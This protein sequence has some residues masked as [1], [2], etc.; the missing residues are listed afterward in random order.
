MNM[1]KNKTIQRILAMALSVVLVLTTTPVTALTAYAQGG[2]AC[3]HTHD[4]ACGY[5]EGADC[6]LG[7]GEDWDEEFEIA[8]AAEATPTHVC[9]EDCDEYYIHTEHDSGCGYIAAAPCKHEHDEDCGGLPKMPEKPG[10]TVESATNTDFVTVLGFSTPAVTATVPLGTSYGDLPL[11]ETVSATVEDEPDPADVPVEW[12]DD[13]SYDGD[14]TGD[15]GFTGDLDAGYILA[16]G[17]NPP[18]FT[19][20][21]ADTAVLR[22]ITAF[23]E[24]PEDI[25]FQ[26]GYAPKLPDTVEGTV[27]VETA[28]IP[29]TWQSEEYDSLGVAGGLAVF[30]AKPAEGYITADGVNPPTI[31]FMRESMLRMGGAGTSGSPLQIVSAAQLAE[32]AA[33]V[34]ASKLEQTVFGVNTGTVYLELMNDI[35]LS[36]YGTGTGWMPIGNLNNRFQGQFNGGGKTVSGLYINSTSSRIG[37]FGHVAEGAVVQNL[38]VVNVNVKGS[39]DV[40]G[41]AGQVNGTVKN[42]YAT[43]SV[44]GTN[45]VGGVA[46]LVNGGTVQ[47]CYATAD[48]SGTN[49][50]GGVAGRISSGS[51]VENCYATADVSGTNHVGGVVGSVAGGTV[52]SCAALNPSVSGTSNVGRVIGGSAGTNNYAYSGMDCTGSDGTSKTAAQI[53]AAG[54][55]ET[56]FNNDSA[57]TYATG[58]LPGFG[59]AVPMPA[60]LLTGTANPFDGGTGASDN[61][62]QISTAEQLA[63]L[64][65]KVNAGDTDYNA[66]YYKLTADIDLSAYS[67]G[68][69]W[70]PIGI[71]STNPFK[72]QFDGGEHTVSG[73]FIN[74][75]ILD[76]IGLFGVVESGATVQN[77]GVVNAEIKGD[78][79]VGGVAGRVSGTV[80]NCY[81]TGSVSGTNSVGGVVGEISGGTVQNCYATGSVNGTRYVGG[82]AG[83]VTGTSATVQNCYA[84]G[85]V[86]GTRYVGGVAGE[87]DGGTVKNCVALNSSVS[88]TIDV[89]RVVGYE[90]GTN[91][92]TNNYAYDYM[93]CNAIGDNTV[94]GTGTIATD[95]AATDFWTYTSNWDGPVWDE[96]VW[97]IAAIKLPGL[98]GK[99]VTM[100][101]HLLGSNAHPF[102]GGDGAELTPYEISTA[103]QLAW[104]AERVN[105][106]SNAYA[107]ADVYYK[108]T[109]DIDL[110][111]YGASFNSGK[112]WIPIGYDINKPFQGKFDGNGKTVSGLYINDSTRYSTGLF[113]HVASGAAVQNLG[114][115]NVDV[116]GYN[117]VGGV[118]GEVYGTVENC[119]ATGSVSGTGTSQY[120]GGV[121]GQILNGTVQN[122]YATGSVTGNLCVGGVAGCVESGTMQNCYATGSVIG[123]NYVGGVA[124]YVNG[125]TVQNCAALNPSVSGSSN[126]GRVIGYNTGGTVAKNYAY[127]GMSC[128]SKGTNCDDGAAMTASDAHNAAFWTTTTGN[129]SGWDNST[130]WTIVDD[131]LPV[132]T[133][134]NGQDGGSGMYLTTKTIENATISGSFT[135]TGSA[136]WPTVTLGGVALTEGTD[137]TASVTGGTSDGTNVGT[138][139]VTITGKGNYT[140]TTTG[141]YTITKATPAALTLPTATTITYGAALSTSD[142]NGGSATGTWEWTVPATIPTVVNSGYEVTFTPADT[143]NYDWTGVSGWDSATSTIRRTVI[144]TVNKAVP[145]A[146]T[147]PTAAT[148]TYGAALSTSALNGGTGAGTFAWTNGTTIPTVTNSGYEVTFTPTDTSNYDWTSVTVKQTVAI[149]VNALQLSW[150]ADG[151]VNDKPYDKSNTATVLTAPTLNGVIS[152]DTVTPSVGTVTFSDA[153]VGT[154]KAVTA[155]GYGITGASAGNYLAPATQPVFAS[156]DITAKQLTWSTGNTVQNKT[157]NQTNAAIV[158]NAPSL[159]GVISGDTV[160]ITVGAVTFNNANVGTNKTVTATGYGITGTDAGNYYVSGQPAF[161]NA[162]IMALQ[163][164]WS[165]DGTVSNKTYDGTTTATVN[166]APSLVGVIGGDTVNITVGTAVFASADAGNG[167]AVTASGWGIAPHQNYNAPTAQPVFASANI[168]KANATGT[169]QTMKVIELQSR[170]YAFELKTLLPAGVDPAQVSGYTV[171]GTGGAT[172]IFQTAPDNS[173]ISGTTLT[174]EIA[175]SATSGQS[176]TITIGFTSANYN[177]SDAAITVEVTDKY[178]VTVSGV[179]AANKTYDGAVFVYGGTIKFTDTVN[180][181]DVTAR[182]TAVIEYSSDGGGSWSAA[183]PKNAGDYKLRISAQAHSDYDATPLVV[184]FTISKAQIT[185]TADNK[186]A[187]VGDAEPA[188]TYQTSG[189]VT[190]ET[191]ATLPTVTC[192]TANMSVEGTYIIIPSGAAAPATGNYETTITYVNGILTVSN[193]PIYTISVSASPSNGG[194]VS[195]SGSVISGSSHTV[196]ATANSNYR[197]TNWTESGTVVSTNA[198]YTFTVSGNRSLVANFSYTGGNGGGGSGDGSSYTPTTPVTTE[199]QPNMPTVAKVSVTGTIQDMVMTTSIIT[200]K[201]AKDA[202]AAAGSN[203]NGIAIQ[204]SITGSGDYMSLTATFERAAL[205]ALKTA[206]VK[207]VQIGSDIIDLTLDTKAITEILAQTTGNITVTATWQTNLSDAAKELIGNRPVFDITIKDD[208]GVTVSDLKGGTA[209]IGIPYK[210]ASTEKTGNLSGVY[211]DGNGKPT[212]LTNSSYDNGKVIFG[213]NSLSI[214]GIG[215]KASAPTFTDTANHWGADNIDFVASRDLISGTSATAFSPDTAITR[216]DFL[217]ALGKLSGANVSGYTTSSFTDVANT[218][219][220]MPY[221][222]WAVQNKIVQDIGNNQFGPDQLISRQDMAVMMVNYAKATSYTLPVSRQAVTFDDDAKISAD[223]KDA[224]K[225][226]HQAGVINGKTGNLFDPQGNVTRAEASTIMRRFVELVID[227]GTA[228]G[229]IQNDAGQ[230][231]YINTNG[232]L[233][234]NTSIDG[235]TIGDDGARKE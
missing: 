44:N 129:W 103:A 136:I 193:L 150:N 122:C 226:I 76:Y 78:N 128:V 79:T 48:V 88:G 61:A 91:T 18:S 230:W 46:G 64:A 11:P 209:T 183:A 65:G 19:V 90:T 116:T 1:G 113:G 231:Q 156:A 112:G 100:P 227:E 132:L 204:F 10:G 104:L 195:G 217:M 225:A 119:Y 124:G 177:I 85:S 41:V 162:N 111:A 5:V 39:T 213:R 152:G 208:K 74:A 158:L 164:T 69:G 120:V 15:Y 118:A 56:L 55:F 12:T 36:A 33:L 200:E 58:F 57:W 145:V 109:A 194:T 138:V 50:V 92:I 43:G 220:A 148:I 167:I 7:C 182:L 98:F 142:L 215:Y 157:Y 233:A 170:T 95:I 97:T 34:N 17:V 62:Y 96:T 24:L 30:T 191:L 130:V 70:T 106:G 121:A 94:Y 102:D 175:A 117:H 59:A 171:G 188:Y 77:L 127:S 21:V 114:V 199:K 201:M 31:A 27:E 9:G 174:V 123:N 187:T 228:R 6:T 22:T 137:F 219:P 40:G 101:V 14:T 63:W 144:I 151:T 168:T 214:Y 52:K 155:T 169:N 67:T 161:A 47:N 149:T 83:S 42:C 212:L 107:N 28:Q 196:T 45:Y 4:E 71:D 189:L 165:A 75:P 232:K 89:G 26:R 49:H 51:T 135:Y 82:V 160:N 2:G 163:L 110:S 207:H 99:A 32:I 184:D 81:V 197:F 8:T 173:S 125:G 235:Y 3:A 13:D 54:F 38:G 66:K 80:Q 35:D 185:I 218:S 153:N 29:V 154:G 147:F 37:L 23:A 222:E 190:G 198:S 140:G 192:P 53:A 210:P 206:G 84:T 176:A 72:G 108:L 216:A 134:L 126:V 202:I 143:A 234:V 172:A 87:V 186:T 159:V 60:H 86:S 221:I 141:S 180:D 146:P 115:A 205:E 178:P 93:D 223:T 229:W 73:L 131:Y 20:T 133:G 179:T 105:E 68:A 203:T 25:R 16:D 224:V 166:T 139:N 181:E 211:V